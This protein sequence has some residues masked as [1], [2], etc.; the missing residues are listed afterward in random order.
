M[1]EKQTEVNKKG[2]KHMLHRN[3]ARGNALFLV[4]LGVV[5][6]AALSFA[7]IKG[8]SGG[9]KATT[10]EQSR[11][12]A[13][14]LI[15]YGNGL[16]IIADRLMLMNGVSDTNASGNGILFSATGANAAYGAA[17]AQPATEIFHASGGGAI[18][19][20]PPADAC[21][22]ACAYEFTGQYT[23]TG[24]GS[25]ARPELAMIVI[26]IPQDVCQKA[27]AIL[28]H[29]WATVP[30]GG[31]LTLVRFSGSNYG[32]GSAVTLTGGGNEFVGKRAFCYR[33]STGGERYIY[34]QTI[35]GR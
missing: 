4:L 28:G 14:E 27:N 9:G 11:L 24:V 33:E 7:V 34:L 12:T 21:L 18:Y 20:A 13:A 31:A 32:G 17:G 10:G 5:L 6:F 16:R 29:G 1:L 22:S 8:W 2:F 35:R 3:P 19:Q 15:Q 26:D 23:V 25:N 30:T